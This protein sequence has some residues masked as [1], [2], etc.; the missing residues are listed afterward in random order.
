MSRKR[1][2]VP[3]E[4]VDLVAWIDALIVSYSG[5][6]DE[7]ESAIGMVIVGRQLG[8]KALRLIHT[9][10]TVAKYEAILGVRIR[11]VFLPEGAG[12]SRSPAVRA[13]RH[14]GNFWKVV[15]QDT[16]L[17]MTRAERRWLDT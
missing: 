14:H 9:A 1:S 8:W 11:D 4:P 6:V 13:A 10:K 3:A 15:S 7:L 12:A 5:P 17:G 2:S 16:D